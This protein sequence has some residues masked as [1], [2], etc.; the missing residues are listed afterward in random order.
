[1]RASNRVR[2]I[3]ASAFVLSFGLSSSAQEYGQDKDSVHENL[4]RKEFSPH[5]GRSFPT[6]VL[7]G[8]THLHTMVSV[9]AGT[10]CRVGQEEA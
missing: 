3:L 7:W 8:D 5:A 6:R 1:M 9:D 4:G 2:V 10:M